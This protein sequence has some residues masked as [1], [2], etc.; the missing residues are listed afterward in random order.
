MSDVFA[1]LMM[2]VFGRTRRAQLRDLSVGVTA[3]LGLSA[4]EISSLVRQA[5]IRMANDF[6]FTAADTAQ[7]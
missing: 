6:G 3:P 2:P 5:L 1:V 4:E 7:I